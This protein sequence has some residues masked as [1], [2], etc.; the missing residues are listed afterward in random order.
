MRAKALLQ[1]DGEGRLIEGSDQKDAE[2]WQQLDFEIG[3]GPR[4]VSGGLQIAIR[5]PDFLV[6]GDNY[7]ARFDRLVDP[8]VLCQSFGG[9]G[10]EYIEQLDRADR[11]KLRDMNRESMNKPKGPDITNTRANDQQP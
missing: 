5:P 1:L 10:G 7:H 9:P 4:G 3:P 6:P 11:S 2:D 8:S